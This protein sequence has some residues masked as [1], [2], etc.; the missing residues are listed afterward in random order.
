MPVHP[1]QYHP[2]PS[3]TRH[4]IPGRRHCLVVPG[5]GFEDSDGG[6][7]AH[8]PT[9]HIVCQ[10]CRSLTQHML[11][12]LDQRCSRLI[13]TSYRAQFASDHIVTTTHR[14][15]P[16]SG[17]QAS[18]PSARSTRRSSRLSHRPQPQPL[19]RLQRDGELVV[20]GSDT[21]HSAAAH[22]SSP[23]PQIVAPSWARELATPCRLP[24]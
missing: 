14:D 2:Q 16:V 6:E 15:I 5:R 18:S 3:T 13:T 4:P 21:T 9:E 23:S 8:G 11:V 12:Q 7:D 20:D 22:G 10:V 19:K 1:A 24:T 17:I